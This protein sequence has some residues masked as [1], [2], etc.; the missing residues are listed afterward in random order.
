MKKVPK[1]PGLWVPRFFILLHGF[2][3]GRLGAA[4]IDEESG[5][6]N[7]AYVNG[8]LFRF[9]KFC[10]EWV[11]QLERDSAGIRTEAAALIQEFYSLPTATAAWDDTPTPAVPTPLQVGSGVGYNTKCNTFKFFK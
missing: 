3:D 6:L 8:K 2:F 10:H 5:E 9:Y 1:L 4:A 7:S 11:S